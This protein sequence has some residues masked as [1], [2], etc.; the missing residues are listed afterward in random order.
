M[1][2]DISFTEFVR[3]P[4][5][6]EAVEVTVD[7]IEQIAEFVGT[8]DHKDDGTPFIKVNRKIV[9]NVLKVY[10]GFYMTRMG[11]NIRCYTKRIFLAQFI[12]QTPEIREWVDFM[13][14]DTIV[15]EEVAS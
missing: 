14:G 6:V 3:K 11:D 9:P 8:M 10:P 12:E 13:N 1:S 15:P 5:V 7:N 4:F 2:N